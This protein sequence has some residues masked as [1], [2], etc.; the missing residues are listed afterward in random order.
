M[1]TVGPHVEDNLNFLENGRRPQIFVIMEDDL[2]FKVNG[3]RPQYKCKWKKTIILRYVENYIDILI[4]FKWK[5]ISV[6]G[7]MEDNLIVKEEM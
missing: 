3:R 2:N 4:F 7:K 1:I 5:T 6:F